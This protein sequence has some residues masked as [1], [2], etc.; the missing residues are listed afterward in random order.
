MNHARVVALSIA[1]AALG[2][3]ACG[4]SYDKRRALVDAEWVV[5]DARTAEINSE[6]GQ[7]TRQATTPDERNAAAKWR[8][9]ELAKNFA[10]HDARVA[11]RLAKEK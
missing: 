4:N 5:T 9:D 3:S 10:D 11:A 1:I 2:L 6:Y 7:R 8:A